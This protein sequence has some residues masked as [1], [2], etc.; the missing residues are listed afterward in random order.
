MFR[1]T[2]HKLVVC[3]AVASLSA[4]VWA[5]E[6]KIGVASEPTSIDPHFNLLTPNEQ[7]RKHV[8][9]A[10][11]GYDELR[12]VKPVL[13]ESW[14]PV[15][16][17]VWEFKLRKDVKFHD[18]TPFTAQDVIYSLCRVSK[19]VNSP[20]SYSIAIKSVVNAKAT[21]P[22]TLQL[23]TATVYPLLP[24]DLSKIGII[25]AKL[26]NGEST[27]FNKDGCEGS[28]WPATKDFNSGKL[29]VGTGPFKFAEFVSGSRVVLTQND[30]YWGGKP[31]WTKV[32]FRPIPNEGPRVAAL[33]SGDVDII[34]SPPAQDAARI[35]GDARFRIASEKTARVI[36]LSA[37]VG[38]NNPAVVGG[39]NPFK[40]VKVR[41]AVSRAIDRQA[42]S[43]KI[44]GGFSV[45][46]MQLMYGSE[47]SKAK[48]WYN[49]ARA[50]ELL[51]EAGYPKGFEVTLAGPNNRYT[52]DE[53]IVQAIAQML[54]AVGIK[55]NVNLMTASVFFSKRAKGEHGFDMSGWLAS[56][57]EMSYPL[58]A[59]VATPNKEKGHGT[60]NVSKYSNPAI[61]SLLDQALETLDSIKRRELLQKASDLAMSD[62]A[63]IP[64]HY[65]VS[66]WAMKSNLDYKGR[67]DQETNAAE[68]KPAK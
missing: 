6:L 65:E 28:S 5:N 14:K 23:E 60:I 11:T 39:G 54:T 37:D 48:G 50:K 20:S 51:A 38:P 27:T 57:G 63:A 59:I 22:Y 18:G 26:N 19:V 33:L 67:W 41:E 42:I 46:A 40:D 58:R 56:T 36:Y 52:N 45:P 4:P 49:P 32:V 68:I 34:E 43:E 55:T 8:F 61:D 2:V 25:S 66:L 24:N 53:Q 62:F 64:I 35:R 47:D 15:S 12:R 44:M 31:H 17:K 21:D 16:P 7:L 1:T 13:A 30:Q 29:A 3:A 10:L 9:E